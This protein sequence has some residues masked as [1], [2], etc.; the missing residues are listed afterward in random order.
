MRVVDAEIGCRYDEFGVG[1]RTR[2]QVRRS[3]YGCKEGFSYRGTFLNVARRTLLS[4]TIST[5]GTRWNCSD[6]F[7]TFS[8]FSNAGTMAKALFFG[9]AVPVG[10]FAITGSTIQ[11]VVPKTHLYFHR[12]SF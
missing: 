8:P 5:T 11:G 10:L 4:L 9:L 2:I 3:G 6:V 12:Y 7:K 1:A